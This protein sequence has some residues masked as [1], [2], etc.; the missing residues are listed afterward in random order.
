VSPVTWIGTRKRRGRAG[1]ES[2]HAERGRAGRD[3]KRIGYARWRRARMRER[4]RCVE[5]QARGAR[6][7]VQRSGP[8]DDRQKWP[9]RLRHPISRLPR[10][11][12]IGIRKRSGRGRGEGPSVDRDGAA[13]LLAPKV[14]HLAPNQVGGDVEIGAATRAG[15]LQ[16]ICNHCF[17][18]R[19]RKALL[20]G[21]TI[22]PSSSECAHLF[23]HVRQEF[24][25]R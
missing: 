12:R 6:E 14:H 2:G 11:R 24:S 25:T 8:V 17:P 1:G 21:P 18:A 5:L 22:Y 9:P 19:A 23:F 3:C 16:W 20:H 13:A 4:S 7:P 10:R 15:N